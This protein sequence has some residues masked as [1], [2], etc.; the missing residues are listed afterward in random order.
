MK[1]IV[2]K[3]IGK[4]VK[5]ASGGFTSYSVLNKKLKWYRT[6]ASNTSELAKFDGQ[7]A[8]I[9]VARKFDKMVE[10]KDGEVRA[11]PTL[12]IEG[13]RKPSDAE[14]AAYNKSV[15]ALNAETLADVE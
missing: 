10:G 2:V 7:V 9:S 6:A 14:L 1:E 13:I 8:V 15:D 3:V 12:V 4:D 5:T 11:Y